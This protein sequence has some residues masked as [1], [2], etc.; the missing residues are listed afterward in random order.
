MNQQIGFWERAWKD[1]PELA[2]S[3]LYNMHISKGVS[4]LVLDVG[5]GDFYALNNSAPTRN[6]PTFIGVDVARNALKSARRKKE[7]R[8]EPIQAMAQFL[9]FKD[10]SFDECVSNRTISLLGEDVPQT[11]K[12][13]RRV[14]KR[15]L[16]FDLVHAEMSLAYSTKREKRRL[17]FGTLIYEN[18]YTKIV[19]DEADV[20]KLTGDL[21]LKIIEMSV[22]TYYDFM[23]RYRPIWNIESVEHGEKKYCITVVA[24]KI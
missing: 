17:D 23:G 14:S 11:L 15:R 19:F 6:S 1:S 22:E 5:C 12:E 2:R 21:D 8:Y 7:D 4:K 10:N 24:E 18:G 13:M 20:H 16:T 9:P 3:T